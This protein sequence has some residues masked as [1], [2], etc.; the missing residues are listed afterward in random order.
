[1]NTFFIPTQP[2]AFFT[3]HPEL[4]PSHFNP[5][6]HTGLNL[7]PRCISCNTPTTRTVTLRCGVRAQVSANKA[8]LYEQDVMLCEACD[9]MRQNLATLTS[10]LR[11]TSSILALI[12]AFIALAISQYYNLEMAWAWLLLLFVAALSWFPLRLALRPLER[13]IKTRWA[14]QLDKPYHPFSLDHFHDPRKGPHASILCL[15]LDNPEQQQH[16][17]KDNPHAIL[18]EAWNNSYTRVES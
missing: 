11:V 3:D 16:F 8:P 2:K 18:A 1:M 15:H 12:T 10:I 9:K 5:E 6:Q 4:Q 17:F 7:R 14:R 13:S